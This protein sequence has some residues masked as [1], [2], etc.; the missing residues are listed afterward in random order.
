MRKKI[1]VTKT[2]DM[3]HAICLFPI[4]DTLKALEKMTRGQ[5]LEVV[6]DHP[7]S[8]Q[9]MPRNLIRQGHKMLRVQRIEGPK[10]RV[11]IEAFGLA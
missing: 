1:M 5:V 3:C 11:L 4:M 6:L 2:M 9:K 10:H 8:L 7:L